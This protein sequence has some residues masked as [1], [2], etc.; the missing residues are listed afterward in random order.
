ML[1]L[2]PRVSWIVVLLGCA[3]VAQGKD[4]KK[5]SDNGNGPPVPF[6]RTVAVDCDQGGTLAAALATE[7]TE[8]TVEFSGTCVGDAVIDRDHTRL[9]GVGSSVIEGAVR[10][11]GASGVVLEDF[12]VTLGGGVRVSNGGN[13]AVSRVDVYESAG[14]GF[15]IENSSSA[16]LT[17]VTAIDNLFADIAAISGSSISLRGSISVANGGSNAGIFVSDA[18][19]V[20]SRAVVDIDGGYYAGIAVQL[21]S[22]LTGGGSGN[23]WTVKNATV[24]LVVIDGSTVG[25][26]DATLIDNYYGASFEVGSGGEVRNLVVD[27]GGIEVLGN[28]NV[29]FRNGGTVQGTPH[30]DFGVAVVIQTSN[31]RF[32]GGFNID[33][34]L[35]L[36]EASSGQA[37]PGSVNVTGTIS[38]EPS[39]VAF[40]GGLVC[41]P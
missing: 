13:V 3:S 6:A 23:S 34:D 18:S 21:G 8:L 9:I 25:I 19:T 11:L 16:T 17:D 28:S 15:R 14:L 27:G 4:V 40:G 37:F 31:A 33:G 12:D 24:G 2:S 29:D 7:A 36:A 26:G 1:G 30:P 39:A 41:P 38:C 10:V 22:T 20:E 32:L 5:N 35:H